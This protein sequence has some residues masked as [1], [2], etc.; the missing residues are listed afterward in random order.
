MRGHFRNWV[1][2][3]TA[4]PAKRRR[5]FPVASAIIAL[6]LLTSPYAQES[7]PDNHPK[8]RTADKVFDDLVRAI[9]DGRTR[10]TLRLL[11]RDSRDHMQVA[12]FVSQHN[13]V[14]V[15]ERV[16]DLF[17]SSGPDSLDA[18]AWL[19]GH[20]LAHRYMNHGW[21]TDF[22]NGVADLQVGQTLQELRQQMSKLVEIET[23]ADY[24][25][26]LFGHIAGYDA[27]GA[28]PQALARIYR[29]YE[30][31]EDVPGYPILSDRQEIAHRAREELSELVS[32]F[33]AGNGLLM[34]QQFEEAARCF[35]F[36]ARTFP[37]REI[38]N[39]AGVSRALAAIQRFEQGALRFA[40]PFELDA[41]TR[42]RVGLKASDAVPGDFDTAQRRDRLLADAQ[43]A[44]ERA[45]KRDPAY[46]PAY[47]NLACVA[48]LRGAYDDALYWANKA[49]RVAGE[50][51]ETE[52]AANARIARGI[53]RAHAEPA[54]REA[55]AED[56]EKAKE[57]A[58]PLALLNLKALAG[59]NAAPAP[60]ARAPEPRASAQAERIGGLT[61]RDYA[62][63]VDAPDAVVELPPDAGFPSEFT[64]YSRE[65]ESWQGLVINTGHST[66]ELLSTRVG[67]AEKSAR[68]VACGELLAKVTSAYGA[69]EYTI[70][71]RQGTHHVYTQPRIV[72]R[73]DAA[74]R[75]EGWSLYRI[76]E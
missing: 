71:G 9:G 23:Q 35:D 74:D 22:G 76:K 44:F 61:A 24:F 32:V 66:V 65:T 14:T 62:A 3:P 73:T 75:V 63:I 56:F 36:I 52:S 43:D 8:Y 59:A 15:E 13:E 1:Q 7:L 60:P 16:Y 38:L 64:I 72:F 67:Y 6:C 34:V 57:G 17:A 68:G 50:A 31:G 47:V 30:L 51:G 55:A 42:L 41:A 27:L 19:L 20:E 29:E 39:N 49:V 53:A 69:A 12:W 11:P 46:A 45:R 21:V 54:N 5:L 48:D 37:S 2:A 10:P 58:R 40:Y 18:L 28:A 70:S 4:A 25:G 33:E 26:S